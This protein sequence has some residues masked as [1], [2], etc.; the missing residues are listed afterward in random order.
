MN[1]DDLIRMI[2]DSERRYAELA[3][4]VRQIDHPEAHALMEQHADANGMADWY[5]KWMATPKEL[6]ESKE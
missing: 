3:A 2:A 4:L 6:A 1:P 5:A